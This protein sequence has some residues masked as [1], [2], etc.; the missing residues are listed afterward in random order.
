[1]P[2]VYKVKLYLY[3]QIPIRKLFRTVSQS[4]QILLKDHLSMLALIISHIYQVLA[5]TIFLQKSSV[6][7]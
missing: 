1:M 3:N 2:S 6:L 5:K 7:S 4:S